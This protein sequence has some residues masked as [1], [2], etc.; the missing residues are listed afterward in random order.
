VS[1]R[2]VANLTQSWCMGSP[3]AA[4]CIQLHIVPSHGWDHILACWDNGS[5]GLHNRIPETEGLKHRAQ[6]VGKV[7][8]VED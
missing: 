8:F 3:K 1:H 2:T 5:A 7:G 4:Q 6:T